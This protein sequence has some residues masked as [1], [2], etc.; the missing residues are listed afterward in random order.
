MSVHINEKCG[1]NDPMNFVMCE[2]NK[3][4]SNT[5]SRKYSRS[6]LVASQDMLQTGKHSNDL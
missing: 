3:T 1:L 6:N 5:I 2:T 4:D